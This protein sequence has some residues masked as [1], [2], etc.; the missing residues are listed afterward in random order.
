MRLVHAF[1]VSI[2]VLTLGCKQEYPTT[3]TSTALDPPPAPAT[4]TTLTGTVA[5][6]P[7][8]P[9]GQPVTAGGTVQM[10]PISISGNIPVVVPLPAQVNSGV[11][12]RPNFD[13]FSWTEFIALNWPA[14]DQG[15]GNPLN[16]NDPDTLR[17]PPS[18]S[19]TVW[20]TYKANW[21]LFNQGKQRP[22]PF[23]SYD[24]PVP[25]QCAP[26]AGQKSLVMVSK[27][28]MLN[29]GVEAF[30]F[31]L[32]DAQQNYVMY[33]VRYGRAAY[34]FMRG[35]DADP[36]RWLYLAKNLNPPTQQSMPS[37]TQ[38]PNVPGAIMMKAAWRDMSGVPQDQQSRYYVVA[39]QV[40]DPATGQCSAKS[41]GLV[42]L[43]IAQKVATLPEWVWSTFEHVDVLTTP[44]QPGLLAPCAAGDTNCS[45]VHGFAHRP[46]STTLLPNKAARQPV[47]AARINPIPTTPQGA[48]TDKV[49][50]AFQQA[51]AGTVWANYQLIVTQWPFNPGTFKAPDNN[52]TYPCWSGDPFPVAGAVNLTMETYFQNAQ[53]ALATAATGGNGCMGCHYGAALY[54]YSWGLKRRPHE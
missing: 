26:Q 25:A 40:F 49:N 14:S 8:D 35:P 1:A 9:C 28:T 5:S 31:P 36:S 44:S 41:V 4:D 43:H 54:D 23:D 15:R 30:S 47:N 38:N 22:T 53:D 24:V 13:W 52:G 39:A 29:D 19:S 12:V 46:Q 48:G 17:N 37:S 33:E 27:G 34:D 7:P 51:L 2:L 18:G 42:G 45:Q 50:A 10:P 3:A 21:E 6:V 16:P 11:Q 20:E 32:V